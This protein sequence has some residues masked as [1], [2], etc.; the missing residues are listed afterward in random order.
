MKPLDDMVRFFLSALGYEPTRRERKDKH[1]TGF[2]L[3]NA[4]PQKGGLPKKKQD[5][6]E[7]QDRKRNSP[8]QVIVKEL[9]AVPD[10]CHTLARV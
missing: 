8:L 2:K 4:L 1:S 6:R 5:G 10:P 3:V 7:D 9:A